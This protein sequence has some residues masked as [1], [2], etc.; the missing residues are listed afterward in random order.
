MS[1]AL[2]GTETGQAQLL[3]A[4]LARQRQVRRCHVEKKQVGNEA[5]MYPWD[6]A[7]MR[8]KARVM[9]MLKP[10]EGENRGQ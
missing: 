7:W 9:R 3:R 5:F 6:V 1:P 4:E 2:A 10:A 8:R